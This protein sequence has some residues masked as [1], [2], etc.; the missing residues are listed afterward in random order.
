MKRI[1]LIEFSRFFGRWYRQTGQ[2]GTLLLS[3]HHGGRHRLISGTLVITS[4]H[5]EEQGR[6]LCSV[7]NSVAS[8]E[9]RTEF[10]VREKLQ[11]RLEPAVLVVEA[12][13]EVLVTCSCTGHPR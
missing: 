4:A 6:Y 3:V 5:P 9:A 11:L 7:N 1:L 12:T 8:A 13:K 2:Y 10:T